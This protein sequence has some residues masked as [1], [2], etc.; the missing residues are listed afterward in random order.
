MSVQKAANQ[1]S[2][3]IN[4]VVVS[5]GLMQKTV[6]VR[7]GQQK[8][9]NHIR[10]KFNLKKHLLVHDPRSSLRTGDIISITPGTRYSKSV[11]HVVT[12]I[13]APFGSPIEERP[14]IPTAEERAKERAIRQGKWAEWG[15][16]EDPRGVEGSEWF[17]EGWKEAEK[18]RKEAKEAKWEANKARKEKLGANGEG[19]GEEVK[20]EA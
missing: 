4:A 18:K 2:R 1:I 10:K 9:N 8:W 5:S 12:S 19:K 11:S 6:K 7:V 14:A 13:I 20:V 16:E 17:V 3:Q 15:F